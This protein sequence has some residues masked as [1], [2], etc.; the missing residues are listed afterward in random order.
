MK[1]NKSP[2]YDELSVDMLK[3]TGPVETE[4]LYRVLRRIWTKNRIHEDWYKGIIIP[5]NKKGDRKQHGTYRRI[6]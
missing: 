2:G 4:W 6:M 1:S 5:I 3:A